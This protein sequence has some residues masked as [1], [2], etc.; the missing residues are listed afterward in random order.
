[1]TKLSTFAELRANLARIP[2]IHGGG[3]GISALAMYKW[4]KENKKLSKDFKFYF[5]YS[6]I[7]GNDYEY[8]NRVLRN[9]ID[10]QLE[11]PCHIGIYYRGRIID[12]KSEVVRYTFSHPVELEHLD[13]VVK[14]INDPHEWNYSF[15]RSVH[16][17]VIESFI[18]QK[19]KIRKGRR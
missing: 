15:N 4:L 16:L 3:C 2:N 17:P 19:L 6:F 10:N 8:N 9:E 7:A 14:M 12:C 5:F 18:G 1:M 11:V 13:A